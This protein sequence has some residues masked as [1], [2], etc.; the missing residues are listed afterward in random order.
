LAS[1]DAAIT[2][3]NAQGAEQAAAIENL[4]NQLASIR[5]ALQALSQ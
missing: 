2:L 1:R 3:L 5:Q 4:N